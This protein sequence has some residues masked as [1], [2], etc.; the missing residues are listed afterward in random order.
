MWSIAQT[1]TF[2]TIYDEKLDKKTNT[3]CTSH[4]IDLFV[5]KLA[6]FSEQNFSCS[7]GCVQCIF[8]LITMSSVYTMYGIGL[9]RFRNSPMLYINPLHTPETI[10][11]TE[12]LELWAL[13]LNFN[14]LNPTP[15]PI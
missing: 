15:R 8:N 3:S 14:G 6:E 13:V 4:P 11:T 2:I 7:L 10:S 1:T 12:Q 5:D 9:I